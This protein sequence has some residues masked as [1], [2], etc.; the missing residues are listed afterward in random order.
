MRRARRSESQVSSGSPVVCFVRHG[1]GAVFRSVGEYA[2]LAQL[3]DAPFTESGF[4]KNLVG[5]L[6]V[7]GWW[8]GRATR[9]AR[10]LGRDAYAPIAFPLDEHLPVLDVRLR[11]GFR[12]GVHGPDRH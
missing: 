12:D 6:P 4:K 2:V 11:K 1:V 7:G 10:K 3:G 9:G 8:T 5:V